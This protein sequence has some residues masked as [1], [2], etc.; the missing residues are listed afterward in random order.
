MI[1]GGDEIS[2]T[3]EGNN[4]GYAQDNPITWFNWELTEEKKALMEFTRSLIALRKA[5]PNLH[6]RKFFQDRQISPATVGT[7][8]IDGRPVRDITWLRPDGN[9]MTQDE[10][11]A[12]WIRC[13][14]LQ[15]SGKTLNDVDRNGE[16]IRDDTFLWWLN[17]HHESVTVTLP[18]HTAE[19][20]KWLLLFDTRNST[21]L[22]PVKMESGQQYE[23]M[24]QSM[25][26]FCE[27]E[28]PET[29]TSAK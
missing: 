15:L 27:L 12:G 24:P 28:M 5:H 22:E 20:R 16:E 8:K 3:Q 6:R 14:G 19:T 18:N 7:Q 25:A 2:R 4:N 10:W 17:S 21:F 1:C 26:L 13:L 11:N 29:L 9:E 23:M